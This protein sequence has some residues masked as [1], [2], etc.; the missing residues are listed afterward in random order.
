MFTLC[1]STSDSGHENTAETSLPGGQ[2]GLVAAK[3]GETTVKTVWRLR[4]CLPKSF[5]GRKKSI[6]GEKKS[7]LLLL[8][9]SPVLGRG[10]IAGP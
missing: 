8:C 1:S 10:Q 4:V 6:Q 3:V 5:L 2:V 7:P 9:G